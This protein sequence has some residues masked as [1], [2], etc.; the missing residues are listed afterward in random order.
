MKELLLNSIVSKAREFTTF[1]MNTG[2]DF[3]PWNLKSADFFVYSFHFGNH[4]VLKNIKYYRNQDNV[5]SNI[6]NHFP[7]VISSQWDIYRIMIFFQDL[8]VVKI[9]WWIMANYQPWL[10][11]GKTTFTQKLNPLMEVERWKIRLNEN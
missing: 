7:Q 8:H 5:C 2:S 4:F 10:Y 9:L 11:F 3:D 1:S 6:L